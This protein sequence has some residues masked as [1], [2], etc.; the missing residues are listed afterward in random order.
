[1]RIREAKGD[2]WAPRERL[3]SGSLVHP[4]QSYETIPN[5][6]EDQ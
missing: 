6:K 3:A 1:M 2:P 5:S 4:L